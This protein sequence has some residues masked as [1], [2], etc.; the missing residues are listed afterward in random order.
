MAQTAAHLVDH[1]IPPVSVRQWVIS[2]PKRL[3]CFLADRQS[4]V[5]ALTRIFIEEIERS[6]C[7]A[8]GLTS[9]A[10]APAT[11]RGWSIEGQNPKLRTGAIHG[12]RS[13]ST[14]VFGQNRTPLLLF[15][16]HYPPV[17]D[18][19][20]DLPVDASVGY[21]KALAPSGN[22]PCVD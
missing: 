19:G 3:C 13:T 14:T 5:A 18:S 15:L 2:V 16:Q 21:R 6:L 20:P 11:A 8:A 10:T 7:A 1:V 12:G 9:A 4:A 22:Y 17:G